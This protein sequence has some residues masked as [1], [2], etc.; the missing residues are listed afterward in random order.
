MS[1]LLVCKARASGV[2]LSNILIYNQLRAGLSGR[3]ATAPLRPRAG[4]PAAAV[5]TSA[6]VL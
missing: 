2:T 4:S 6:A 1:V 3:P 5:E